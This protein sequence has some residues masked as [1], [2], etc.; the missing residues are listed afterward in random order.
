VRKHFPWIH[1]VALSLAERGVLTGDEL[2]AM[3]AAELRD[4]MHQP[5]PRRT[6]KR[7][8]ELFP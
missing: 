8:T 2:G 4:S 5:K 3:L 1:E 6:N 7:Q